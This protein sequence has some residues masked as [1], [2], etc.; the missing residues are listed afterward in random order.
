M[1]QTFKSQYGGVTS[2]VTIDFS[3]LAGIVSDLEESVKEQARVIIEDWAVEVTAWMK[4]NAPWTDRTTNARTSL[5]VITSF[6][7]HIIEVVLTGGVFYMKY[8]ELFFKGLDGH[9]RF[10][11]LKPAMDL[12]GQVLIERLG[13]QRD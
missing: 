7:E 1:A 2:E 5:G 13:A 12:W 11:I 9:P 6:K 4:Q 10:A 3:G 8:L